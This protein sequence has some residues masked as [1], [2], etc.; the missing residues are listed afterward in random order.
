MNLPSDFDQNLA[1][2]RADITYTVTYRVFEVPLK[3]H[4]VNHFS[5]SRDVSGNAHWLEE[6]LVN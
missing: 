3:R 4:P 5:L 1:V 6:P 2:G